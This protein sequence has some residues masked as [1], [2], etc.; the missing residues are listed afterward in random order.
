MPAS[1][2]KHESLP[3]FVPASPMTTELQ[4]PKTTRNASH[5]LQRHAIAAAA[6]VGIA[7]DRNSSLDSW[8]GDWH[9]EGSLKPLQDASFRADATSEGEVESA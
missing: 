3:S 9:E 4:T 1:S 2:R 7:T 5:P 6:T 8:D